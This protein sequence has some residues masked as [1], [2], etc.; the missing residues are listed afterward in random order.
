MKYTKQNYQ[1]T[2]EIYNFWYHFPIV[3]KPFRSYIK[4]QINKLE[5]PVPV[6][7]PEKITIQD[8]LNIL[9]MR[10]LNGSIVGHLSK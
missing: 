8:I 5:K 2:L 9:E 10:L 4:E 1:N 7:E 6:P 3:Q